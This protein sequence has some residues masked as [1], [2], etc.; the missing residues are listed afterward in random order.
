MAIPA[1]VILWR[2]REGVEK[3]KKEK[4]STTAGESRWC[5]ST[6]GASSK[7][8]EC[9]GKTQGN[10]KGKSEGRVEE[11]PSASTSPYFLLSARGALRKGS[12]GGKKKKKKKH[13]T[14]KNLLQEW[15]EVLALS[16]S[17]TD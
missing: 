3:G 5:P 10:I 9:E 8:E 1:R 13:T 17:L 6:K 12:L 7:G 11:L 14:R 4:G 2:M 16:R 15:G